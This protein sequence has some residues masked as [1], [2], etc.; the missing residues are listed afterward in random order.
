MLL[1]GMRRRGN[2]KWPIAGCNLREV[3]RDTGIVVI[4]NRL[5]EFSSDTPNPI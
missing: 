1:W 5:L 2:G 4:S 3:M